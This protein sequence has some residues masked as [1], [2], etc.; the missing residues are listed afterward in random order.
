M[1]AL[2]QSGIPI[3]VIKIPIEQL[4]SPGC[5]SWHRDFGRY[6]CRSTKWMELTWDACK[7]YGTNYNINFICWSK[8]IY[9]L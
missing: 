7:L 3:P 8:L 4:A 6:T 1:L 9:C 2:L 5:R